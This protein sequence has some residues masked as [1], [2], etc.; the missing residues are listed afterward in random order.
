MSYVGLRHHETA[1]LIWKIGECHW[2]NL[3]AA[4]LHDP[5]NM[6]IPDFAIEAGMHNVDKHMRSAHGSQKLVWQMLFH[7]HGRITLRRARLSE[8]A[9]MDSY[10]SASPGSG[11]LDPNMADVGVLGCSTG[12]A[13]AGAASC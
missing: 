13:A 1:F 5:S 6:P 3:T 12:C 10:F 4:S 2:A 7:M 8:R 11:V 9:T